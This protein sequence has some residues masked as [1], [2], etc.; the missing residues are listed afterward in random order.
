M[1]R[2]TA[3]SIAF[4][5][6]GASALAQQQPTLAPATPPPPPPPDY[7]APITHE[8]SLAAMAAAVAEAK[9]MNTKMSFT[10][11]GPTGDLIAFQKMDN[12]ANATVEVSR[13]KARTAALYKRPS[14]TFADALAGGNSAFMT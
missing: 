6:V 12:T 11:V 3:I 13:A 5:L 7:G 10:I 14:K 4:A 9:K 2:L 1:K 8:Q